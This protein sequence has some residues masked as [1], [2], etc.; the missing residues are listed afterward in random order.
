VSFAAAGIIA[1]AGFV[2]GLTGFGFALVATPVLTLL[3]DAKTAV[4]LSILLSVPPVAF[5]VLAS[6][7][8]IDRRWLWRA[9]TCSLL[10]SPLGGLVLLFV[11]RSLLGVLIGLGTVAASALILSGYSRP[12]KNPDR[13]GA[14]AGFLGG[15]LT[16]STNLGGPP[17][18]LSLVNQ[19]VDQ[20]RLRGSVNAFFLLSH[21]FTFP[22]LVASG[23]ITSSVVGSFLSLIPAAVLTVPVG[24]WAARRLPEARFRAVV[25]WVV[26][27]SGLAL[28]LREASRITSI[29]F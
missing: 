4:L 21:L 25:T 17:V 23:L 14:I 22:V 20:E 12:F 9:G 11:S 16:G 15:L 6:R 13:A 19:G 27:L 29:L 2:H 8:G 5:V 1:V 26:L 7:R 10:G 18:V 3:F 24:A 28:L